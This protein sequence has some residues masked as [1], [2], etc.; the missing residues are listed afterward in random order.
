MFLEK[1]GNTIGR[2]LKVDA[3]TS[4]A[5]RGHYARLCVELPLN[6]AVKSYVWIGYNKQQ[7]LYEFDKL[8]YLYCGHLG[9]STGQCNMIKQQ[10]TNLATKENKRRNKIVTCKNKCTRSTRNGR[11]SRLARG[12]KKYEE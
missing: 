12:R 6:K 3:C 5:L 4:T 1:V 7:V 8:L 11:L 9:Y 2:L 10:S